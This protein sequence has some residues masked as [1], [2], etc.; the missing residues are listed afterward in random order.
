[1]SGDVWHQEIKIDPG[2]YINGNLKPD[3]GK[4]DT[5]PVHKP[6]AAA[7]PSASPAS[8]SSASASPASGGNATSAPHH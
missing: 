3:F 8:G 1:M 5:K 4:S 2:A 7:A 6:V